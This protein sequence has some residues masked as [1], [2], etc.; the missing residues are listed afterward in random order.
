MKKICMYLFAIIIA[1]SV[2]C[3][4][5]KDKKGSCNNSSYAQDEVSQSNILG[6][7]IDEPSQDKAIIDQNDEKELASLSDED[8]LFDRAVEENNAVAQEENEMKNFCDTDE[9]E[10]SSAGEVDQIDEFVKPDTET[11]N[12]KE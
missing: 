3:C 4:P 1:L 2:G 10:I 8:E 9:K 7:I 6:D 12:V 5:K 11:E